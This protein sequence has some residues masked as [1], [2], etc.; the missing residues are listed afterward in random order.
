MPAPRYS[1][2]AVYYPNGGSIVTFGGIC[3][4]M[5]NEVNRFNVSNNQW[6]A[7]DVV[8]GT[9]P[10]PRYG[11]VAFIQGDILYVFGGESGLGA[12][13]DAHQY[14]LVKK[15]WSVIASSGPSGRSGASAAVLLNR[16]VF[17]GVSSGA[18]VFND[19]WQ[20][21]LQFPCQQYTSCVDCTNSGPGCGW[22]GSCV[23]GDGSVAFV[24]STCTPA[25]SSYTNEIDSCPEAFPSYAI[26]LIVIGGVVLVGIIIFAIMKLRTGK[27]SDYQEIS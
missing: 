2:N 6:L 27:S 10:T 14:D 16:A 24:P 7:T 26:A 4:T 20:V 22:C 11:A 3:G 13:N 18:Q 25:S 23:A 8:T 5:F 9:P 1:A 17:Y 15:N 19:T 12:M 21:V